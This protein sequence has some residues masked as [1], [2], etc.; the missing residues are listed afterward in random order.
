MEKRLYGPVGLWV[1]A[2]SRRRPYLRIQTLQEGPRNEPFKIGKRDCRGRAGS[3]VAAGDRAFGRPRTSG[4][5]A[6]SGERALSAR[7]PQHGKHSPRAERAKARMNAEWNRCWRQAHA[8]YDPDRREWRKERDW[9][10]NYDW[11]PRRSRIA[12]QAVWAGRPLSALTIPRE[13]LPPTNARLVNSH[14]ARNSVHKVELKPR[15]SALISSKA[16]IQS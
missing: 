1:G 8:W 16:R 5:V 12:L 2:T 10:D 9:D 15:C 6:S 3:R 7:S 11:G 14:P 13:P 4:A